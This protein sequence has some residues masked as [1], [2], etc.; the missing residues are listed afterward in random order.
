MVMIRAH[1]L[2]WLLVLVL[3][4]SVVALAGCGRKAASEKLAEGMMEKTLEKA[5]GGDVDL[6]LGGGGKDVTIKTKDGTTTMSETTEWPS[7]IFTEVP[8]FT[9]GK[10]ERVSRTTDTQNGQKSMM[11]WIVELQ[12]GGVEKYE[13]ELEGAGWESQMSI[14]G[15]EGGMIS[16]QKGNLGLTVSYN[17]QDHTAAFNVFSGAEE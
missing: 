8:R 17:T 10:V 13:K 4:V 14:A 1:R 12:E 2:S 6:D 15:G 9:Y 5:T 16:A 3:A 7:D 11:V